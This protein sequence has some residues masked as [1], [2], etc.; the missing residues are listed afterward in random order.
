MKAFK[1]K[2][3]WCGILCAV[4]LFGFTPILLTS[5]EQEPAEI[6]VTLETDMSSI[7]AAINNAN[8]AL[9]D[10]LATI[11]KAMS[12]GLAKRVYLNGILHKAYEK[13]QL[14]DNPITL[15]IK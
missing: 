13:V 7:I 11:E 2:S 14:Q 6:N 1:N 4:A 9:S 3:F 10:K 12:D 5:C 8:T 15:Q